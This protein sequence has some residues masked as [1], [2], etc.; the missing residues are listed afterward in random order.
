MV[1]NGRQDVIV[2]VDDFRRQAPGRSH[3]EHV[4]IIALHLP[5]QALK[6]NGRRLR[7]RAGGHGSR[8]MPFLP[9]HRL[10][11]FFHGGADPDLRQRL[12]PLGV[13]FPAGAPGPVA[14]DATRQNLL[15]FQRCHHLKRA[16]GE[17]PRG[18]RDIVQVQIRDCRSN[19]RPVFID[20]RIV[21]QGDVQLDA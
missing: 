20:D 11:R 21:N 2:T 15:V 3:Q 14:H 7:S 16:Q 9:S 13:V 5:A 18:P 8:P 1:T 12:A 19:G 4:W 17:S 10:N 6:G